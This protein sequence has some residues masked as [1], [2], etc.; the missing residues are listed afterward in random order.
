MHPQPPVIRSAEPTRDEG[1]IC[2]K[3]FDIAAEGL[4]S[5]LFGRR[6]LDLIAQAFA[7]TSNEYSHENT[8]FAVHEDRIVGQAIGFTAEQRQ[9]FP[10]NPLAEFAGYPK[11]RA[12]IIGGLLS[13]MFRVLDGVPEGDFYLLSLAVDEHQRGRG[14][15]SALIEAMEERARLTE[16]RRF[17][18]HVAAKNAAAQRLYRHHGLSIEERWPKHLYLGELGLYRMA[19]TL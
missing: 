17:S 9:G 12:G 14:V 11:V 15:G 13:P 2:A 6:M 5:I 8:V 3:Y 1:L 19:K 4:F 18:L 16:S 10:K 7:Q